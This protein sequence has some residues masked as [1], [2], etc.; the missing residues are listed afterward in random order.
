MRDLISGLHEL[1]KNKILHLDIKPEN[2]LFESTA[3]DSIIKITDF[4]LSKVIIYNNYNN[5]YI[6]YYIVF[7][8]LV[9]Y[10]ILC[11]KQ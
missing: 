2:I 4:G 10:N 3:E 6:N 11:I 9:F 8:N 5:I 7:Y 1:H